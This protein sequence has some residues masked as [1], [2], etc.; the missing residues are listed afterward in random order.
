MTRPF[1]QKEIEAFFARLQKMDPEPR[2]ELSYRNPYTLLVA[3][4]LS[5]QAKWEYPMQT[6]TSLAPCR[7]V[8]SDCPGC[9]GLAAWPVASRRRA[10]S[11]AALARRRLVSA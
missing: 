1:S 2:S 8:S 4:V 5:A 7:G 6:F 9:R 3:V 11:W 10:L